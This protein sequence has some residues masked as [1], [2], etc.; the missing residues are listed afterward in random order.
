MRVLSAVCFF[1]G[2]L[3]AGCDGPPGETGLPGPQGNTGETGPEGPQ[4]N[5][6]ETGET[7]PDGTPGKNAYLT[8]PGLKLTIE[9][10]DLTD[11]KARFT[12][13]ITDDA[14]VPLDRQGKFTEGAVN[15]R[16]SLSWLDPGAPGDPGQ[17]T[18]YTTRVQDS[19]L[20]G[21]SAV[22]ASA[23]EGG[24]FTEVDFDDGVYAYELKTEID[25]TAPDA[26]H[27]LHVWAT[28]T[29]EGVTYPAEAIH[30]FVPGGADPTVFRDIVRT[31][32]C[33][34]CHGP[35]K[36]HEGARRDVAGCITCHTDQSTDPDTGNTVDFTVMVHKIHRGKNL[37]SV[38]NGAPYQIIGFGQSVHDFST[39]GY[40]QELQRCDTCHTGAQ[41]QI[42]QQK[43][44]R[45][46][47][48]SCHDSVSFV[49]PPPAGQTLHAGGEM[50]DDTKCTVCHPPAGG[51]EGI[52]TKHLTA[53][54][55]PASP[56]VLVDILSVE[57]TA[58][59]E[60]PE[61]VFTVKQDGA[62]VDILTTPMT[63]LVFTVAGPTTDYGT[64]WQN[65]AQGS[66][67]T[68]TLVAEGGQFRYTMSTPVPLLATGSYAVGAEAYFQV[69]GGPRYSTPNP[70][71]YVAVTDPVA[72]PRREIVDTGLCNNCHFK[73][74]AHGGQRN[75]AEYCVF[76]HNP[77]QA[78][79]ERI[80]RFEDK[81]VTTQ[82]V[83]MRVFIH[84]L[85][86]GE[87]LAIQ[88][89]I[90]GG[91]PAPSK[92][93]PAGTPIDFGEVRFPGDRKACWTC[94]K[95]DSYMLPLPDGLLPSKLQTLACT[96]APAA[97]AD[98]YCDQRIVESETFL[99]PETAAC[100]GCHDAK[101]VLAH[102]ETNTTQSGAEAC[103]TCHGP[104]KDFDVQRVHQPTP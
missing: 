22:Q 63:R 40:P 25:V 92:A 19:P 51:L 26:T 4:G 78:G 21:N 17:Y 27:T 77:N 99:W 102:A 44:T 5:T 88:P 86:M 13:R 76:C 45:K 2:A 58:P 82:S 28:R 23:D 31:D 48:G 11:K 14:G 91:F 64:F 50:L 20:S 52:A 95:S 97:D 93:N 90:L 100:T 68:G 47:C 61:V 81:T 62:P 12:F 54:I 71:K 33:N 79:D 101:S 85:H 18:A 29:F 94:H 60:S 9:S 8:G 72:E 74:G 89:Y 39:V 6:G 87:E 46:V 41:G 75:N 55:D 43:P 98:A 30:H 38:Q 42:W 57:K 96:E 37:P 53:L 16:S 80:E 24:T 15:V 1:L 59:G 34:Q 10:V 69:S 32:A 67:A 65:T 70:V 104:G 103:A 84:R 36:A 3:I 56:E 66:G 35:L 73:L 83:D 49:D 7:G